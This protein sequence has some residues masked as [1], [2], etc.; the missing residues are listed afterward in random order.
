MAAASCPI[1]ALEYLAVAASCWA[2]AAS[3]PF[4]F[5][6]CLVDFACLVV[7]AA[8]PLAAAA[9]A[10][11]PRRSPL[12]AVGTPF[13]VVHERRKSPTAVVAW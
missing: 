4:D 5:A 1:A 9:A 2:V 11:V 10:T 8:Y 6:S 3:F 7:A 13:A 12:L